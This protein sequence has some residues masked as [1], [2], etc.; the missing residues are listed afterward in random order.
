M[1]QGRRKRQRKRAQANRPR[2]L[3]V[4]D[5]YNPSKSMPVKLNRKQLGKIISHLIQIQN[6]DDSSDDD[7][8]DGGN[9]SAGRLA[10]VP[11]NW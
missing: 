4:P 8:D 1:T 9:Y 2:T 7:V 6:D 11:S 10:V 3:I 5:V